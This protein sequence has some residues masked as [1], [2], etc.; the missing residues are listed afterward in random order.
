MLPRNINL[1]LLAFSVSLL[2]YPAAAR[3][4]K[5]RLVSEAIDLVDRYY[6]DPIDNRK[7]VEAAMSGITSQLDE[8]SEF[9]PPAMFGAFQDVIDQEFAGI[10]ILVEQPEKGKSVRVIT[11]L[12]GSPAIEAGLL[13]GDEILKIDGRDVSTLE[14][15]EVSN[16]LRGPIRTELTITVGRKVDPEGDK[17]VDIK[18]SRRTIEIESV[19]GDHRD[20]Q[21]RWVFRLRESP[22]IAYA[23]LTSFGEKTVV[24]LKEVLEALNNDFD[25]LILDVRANS[26][27]LLDAAVE[28]CDDFLDSGRIVTIKKRGGVVD[29]E[30]DATKGVLVHSDIPMVVLIDGNSASASE[31]VAACLQDY[32][33]ATIVG[34][35]SFGKGTVQSVLPLDNGRSAFKLTTAR[36]YRP[37][38]RNIHRLSGSKPEDEWGVK[39]DEGMEVLIDEGGYKAIIQLWQKASFPVISSQNQPPAEHGS[40]VG[41]NPSSEVDPQLKRAIEILQKD[42]NQIDVPSEV[43]AL[44]AA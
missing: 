36:Y 23:R 3:A 32:K 20:K 22:R 1:I 16:Q 5:S 39:P 44:K 18:L 8:N 24:E 40:P 38:G 4:K 9:I 31:I 12:V 37:S 30:F 7:L 28:V 13:P 42:K 41:G 2:C 26:G 15:G 6:V 29:S 14:I 43:E 25:S 11:P 19:L 27:G 10:G 35:R 17:T 34:A 21:N 33:R